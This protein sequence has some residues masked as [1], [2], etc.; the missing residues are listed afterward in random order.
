MKIERTLFSRNDYS[1][2]PIATGV[3]GGGY[4]T[5]R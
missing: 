5:I 3:E 1:S 2:R 4:V